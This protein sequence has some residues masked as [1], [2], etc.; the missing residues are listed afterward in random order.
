MSDRMSLRVPLRD[1]A[2]RTATTVA[3]TDVTVAPMIMR[4]LAR[5]PHAANESL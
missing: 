4:S 3:P 1:A 5:A 2:S